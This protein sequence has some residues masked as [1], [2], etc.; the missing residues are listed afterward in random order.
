MDTKT[1]A[2]V[3]RDTTPSAGN[4]WESA[5]KYFEGRTY[6]LNDTKMFFKGVNAWL[7]KNRGCYLDWEWL[8]RLSDKFYYHNEWTEYWWVSPYYID[9]VFQVPVFKFKN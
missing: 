7:L 2:D 8:D 1:I 3:L 5:R 6:T 9:F 4:L